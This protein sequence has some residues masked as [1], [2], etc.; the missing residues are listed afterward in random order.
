MPN[1]VDLN[2]LRR[3]IIANQKQNENLPTD[4]K[5]QILVN[6]EGKIVDG[7]KA[8]NGYQKNLSQVHQGVFAS[9][10]TR[11]TNEKKIVQKKFPA[12]TRML[13]VGQIR[14]W[15]YS[16]EDEFLRT[17][18]MYAYFDGNVYQ[19]K[20]V[21]PEVEGKYKSIHDCHLYTD[22]RICFGNQYGGGLPS[23]EYAY[24][25]SVI[26]ANGFTIYENERKYPFSDNNKW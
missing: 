9:A 8:S 16:F 12:N 22:G 2:E 26:W 17:Y 20:V 15:L 18:K 13:Q 4:K 10:S 14:G 19:V 11:L 3:K 7:H 23:L 24:A 1:E 5:R 25:K 6:K 21:S